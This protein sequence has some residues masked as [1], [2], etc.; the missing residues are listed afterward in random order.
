MFIPDPKNGRLTENKILIRLGTYTLSWENDSICQN[1][2][3]VKNV[4]YF[5]PNEFM[6]GV[7]GAFLFLS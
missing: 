2:W 1:Y 5:R 3:F 4:L 6:S 7:G